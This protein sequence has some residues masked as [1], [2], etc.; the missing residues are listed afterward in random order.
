MNV[1][2]MCSSMKSPKCIET[3]KF[4]I[5]RAHYNLQNIEYQVSSLVIASFLFSKLSDLYYILAG[6]IFLNKRFI[7]KTPEVHLVKTL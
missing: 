7:S 4:D 5:K 1:Y 2:C 6:K 3:K